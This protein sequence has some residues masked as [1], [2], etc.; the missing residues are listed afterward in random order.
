M[1]NKKNEKILKIEDE[2]CLV[3]F[4]RLIVSLPDAVEKRLQENTFVRFDRCFDKELYTFFNTDL[5]DRFF[6]L[7]VFFNAYVE[8]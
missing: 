7:F 8:G 4:G 3:N 5:S 1:N 2:L 6:V